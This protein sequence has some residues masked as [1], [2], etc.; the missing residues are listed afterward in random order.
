MR[1][2]L[3]RHL[4]LWLLLSTI[5]TA[6][7][8]GVRPA[9]DSAASTVPASGPAAAASTE[10]AAAPRL[11]CMVINEASSSVPRT[12]ITIH[13][14]GAA[15]WIPAEGATTGKGG[16]CDLGFPGGAPCLLMLKVTAPGYQDAQVYYL[17]DPAQVIPWLTVT[18]KGAAQLSGTVVTENE[19]PVADAIVTI[20]TPVGQR[21]A[22]TDAQGRFAFKDLM[23]AR[24]SVRVEVPGV[25]AASYRVDLARQNEPMQIVLQPQRRVTLRIVDADSKPVPN[26]TMQILTPRKSEG[27]T[28]SDGRMPI[29]GIGAN[30]AR[31]RVTLDDKFYCLDQPVVTLAVEAGDEPVELELLAAR[32]GRITGHVLEAFEGG[33]TQGIPAA[34]VW[35]V[36]DGRVGR[37]VTADE[38]GR[39]ELNAVPADSYVVAAGDPAYAVAVARA[40]VQAGREVQ[41]RFILTYGATIRGT[42]V[43]PSGRPAD[44]AIVR[45][46]AWYPK[47]PAGQAEGAEPDG[48]QLPWQ[49]TRADPKGEYEL[50]HL[51]P[52]QVEIEAAAQDGAFRTTVS[53]H[54]P[55]GQAVLELRIAL[56]SNEFKPPI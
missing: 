15:G 47:G 30:A 20:E 1:I 52:G 22:T 18:L 12:E 21:Q 44:R 2:W 50:E 37:N 46:L 10:P 48:I 9:G 29:P 54:V 51:P 34:S 16:A 23:P 38:A 17:P 42:V 53:V 26:L 7:P 35:L 32:G 49:A 56:G 8:A 11:H 14:M 19:E 4:A 41:L 40:P 6:E 27:R 45:V 33:E 28:D 25:G 36:E 31:V 3:P 13:T 39:F 55:P 24:V 5:A 43:D